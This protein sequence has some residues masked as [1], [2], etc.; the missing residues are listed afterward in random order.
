MESNNTDR[1]I[2]KEKKKQERADRAFVRWFAF[3]RFVAK[4]LRIFLPYK[5][6]DAVKSY[7]DRPYVLLCNH[8]SMI[9]VMYP[10]TAMKKPV[11]FM[12][13]KICGTTPFC[14]GSAT[15]AGAYP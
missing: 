6:H 12:A 9:D 14:A 13:K 5:R 4:V 7:E 15:N 3:L 8:F 11:R 2:E 10:A 1:E